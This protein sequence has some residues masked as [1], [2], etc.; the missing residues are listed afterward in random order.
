MPICDC[1]FA[2]HKTIT[3]TVFLLQ[4][5]IIY[6]FWFSVSRFCGHSS[7]DGADTLTGC[8]LTSTGYTFCKCNQ[9]NC[10]AY[11]NITAATS[12][13]SSG[14]EDIRIEHATPRTTNTRSSTTN[15]G[16]FCYVCSFCSGSMGV[17]VDCSQ[18]SAFRSCLLTR[19]VN[20]N[21]KLVIT[22]QY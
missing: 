13:T 15:S 5:S 3:E 17:L 9:R 14:L 18:I 21:G 10:N 19:D 2:S 11:P 4:Y 8:R 1:E 16:W 12:T 6:S 22:I 20:G 7:F